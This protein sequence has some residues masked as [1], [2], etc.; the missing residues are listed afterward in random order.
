MC[1]LFEY[2]FLTC[3]RATAARKAAQGQNPAHVMTDELLEQG[4]KRENKL[5]N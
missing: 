3:S 2:H 4:D 5:P 1:L